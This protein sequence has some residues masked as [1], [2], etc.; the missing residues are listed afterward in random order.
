M[1]GARNADRL[2]QHRQS[3]EG[4]LDHVVRM[5]GTQRLRQYVRYPG[6]LRNSTHRATGDY[7]G[8]MSSRFDQHLGSAFLGQLNVRN[9]AMHDRNLDQVLLGIF[10]PLR[11][12]FLYFLSL[13]ESMTYHAAL[14]T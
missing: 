8:T 5:G 13:S 12:R 9:S 14:V 3:L 10:D 2:T 1:T 7:T 4:R 6:A 11:D